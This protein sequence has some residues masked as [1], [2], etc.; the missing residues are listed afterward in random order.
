MKTII[1][2]NL[3]YNSRISFWMKNICQNTYFS[4]TKSWL[5][6][7]FKWKSF[8]FS[9]H[10]VKCYVL[11]KSVWKS[12]MRVS[13]QVKFISKDF[14]SVKLH[15]WTQ[16]LIYFEEMKYSSDFLIP[17]WVL[18]S[19]QALMQKEIEKKNGWFIEIRYDL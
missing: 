19:I 13:G 12:C 9:F 11:S 16:T 18:R 6:K 14:F 5:P 4:R 17:M 8:Y 2:S 1:I 3:T 10:L 7:M 15:C